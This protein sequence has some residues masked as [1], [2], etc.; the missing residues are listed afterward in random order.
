NNASSD[1]SIQRYGI[2]IFMT[3]TATKV[4]GKIIEVDLGKKQHAPSFNKLEYMFPQ[5]AAAALLAAE[6]ITS[7]PGESSILG[8]NEDSILVS[9]FSHKEAAQKMKKEALVALNQA[10]RLH[11][12]NPR[13]LNNYLQVVSRENASELE[14][15]EAWVNVLVSWMKHYLTREI[16]PK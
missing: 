1:E 16:T 6:G 8:F 4:G 11:W 3:I 7:G 9:Q 12:L 13:G 14:I 15:S 2:D 5:I 10:T